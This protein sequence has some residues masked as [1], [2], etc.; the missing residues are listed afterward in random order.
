[1][2]LSVV[3]YLDTEDTVFHLI[4]IHEFEKKTLIC[5]IY[6]YIDNKIDRSQRNSL[7]NSKFQE[8]GVR[9]LVRKKGLLHPSRCCE[10]SIT[11]D[12]R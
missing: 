12:D 2:N 5:Q 11:T 10:L 1:M 6:Q 4:L 8:S 7:G 9:L 3:A